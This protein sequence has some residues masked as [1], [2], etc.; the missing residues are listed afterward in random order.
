MTVVSIKAECYP[1]SRDAARLRN[2]ALHDVGQGLVR[3]QL[4]VRFPSFLILPPY[5]LSCTNTP[6]SEKMEV[7]NEDLKKN[8]MVTDEEKIL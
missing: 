2:I 3:S 4:R 6:E 5:L 7:W 8:I 1:R